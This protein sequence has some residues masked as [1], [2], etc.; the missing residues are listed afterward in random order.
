M[1]QCYLVLAVVGADATHIVYVEEAVRSDLAK[2]P[3]EE[4]KAG[5]VLGGEMLLDQ[6]RKRITGN[7][8]EQPGLEEI[9]KP[10]RLEDL[11]KVVSDYKGKEWEQFVNRRRDWGRDMVLLLAKK[12]TNRELAEHIGRVD[13]SAVA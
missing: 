8:K 2:S 9:K 7:I 10:L 3:W 12:N 1:G 5:F 4:V 13:D 11:V 6:V